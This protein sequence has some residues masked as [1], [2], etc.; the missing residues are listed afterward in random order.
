VRVILV[1]EQLRR[2]VPGGI[3]R[4][5]VGLMQGLAAIADGAG[6]VPEV[7][8][9]ASRP[10]PGGDPLAA[11]RLPLICSRLPGPALTRGW[12]LGVLDVPG[13][14]DVVHA[15][16]LAT[17]PARHAALVVT[18]HD[19]TWR[20]VPDAFP[21]RGRRWHEAAFRRARHRAARIVVPSE[22]VG[23][24]IVAAG[25]SA[26]AVSVIP[27]GADHLPPPDHA[28]AT[29][30]LRRLGVD[31]DYLMSVGTREPRKNLARLLDAYGR[32]RPSLPAPWPLV[33][34]G[35]AGWGAGPGQRERGDGD[36][37][38]VD[39]SGLGPAPGVLLAGAVDDAT[40]AALYDRARLLAYVPLT[41][42]FGFP[43]VEAMRAGVP[44]V[45]SPLPSLDGAGLVVDPGDVD[46][47]A[48]ALVAAASDVALRDEL[49]ARG[50]KRVAGLTW[51]ASARAHAALWRSIA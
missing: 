47:I 6:N 26:G 24:D 42:G 1:V 21:P 27:H 4:Y 25:T 28:A 45:S 40:L 33:V 8:L 36:A 39:G 12:D 49:V 23:R 44:V 19:L 3:G 31:G 38:A 35:P 5:A 2:K 29:A 7:S 34:V 32:A 16:S 11:H 50:T 51:A 15:V 22:P 37:G 41:E 18:M 43:P 17:P 14:Y 9:Y 10:P 20:Q 46:D 48:G 30:L 13:G